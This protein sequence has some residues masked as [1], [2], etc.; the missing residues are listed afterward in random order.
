MF[1]HQ[2]CYFIKKMILRDINLY[3]VSVINY[4]KPRGLSIEKK[5]RRK[6][7]YVWVVETLVI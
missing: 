2:I 1:P 5:A 7:G 6:S 3:I 4:K